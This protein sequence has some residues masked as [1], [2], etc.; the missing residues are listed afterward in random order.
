[1]AN[2][3]PIKWRPEDTKKLSRAV[4]KYNTS[5]TKLSKK[6]PEIAEAG[7]YPDK[8]SVKMLKER[9]L[10]RSDFNREIS[11]INRWFKPKARDIITKSG[12]KM[13]RYSY[14]ESVYNYQ[15]EMS[16]YKKNL[17]E[18]RENLRKQSQL[19]KPPVSPSEKLKQIAKI[20]A[21][22]SVYN[23]NDEENLQNSWA[24]Y[25][26]NLAKRSS[27]KYIQ[28]TNNLFYTNYVSALGENFTPEHANDIQALMYTLQ[29]TGY[30]MYLLTTINPDLDIE[31]IYGPD[32]EEAKY[33]YVYENLYKTYWRAVREGLIEMR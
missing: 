5:I 32:T 3:K 17:S 25:Q 30:E 10:T 22:N 18:A 9:I 27:D 21:D 7:L 13:T 8:I 1:M 31:F 19:G 15:R 12:I 26:M 14:R 4:Q 11:A 29:L 16:I 33:N 24:V 20:R 28:E 2:L 23:N 6:N